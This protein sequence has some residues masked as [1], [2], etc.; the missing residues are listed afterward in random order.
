MSNN[1]ITE[2]I[3]YDFIVRY[4]DLVAEQLEIS[5]RGFN[6]EGDEERYAWIKVQLELYRKVIDAEHERRKARDNRREPLS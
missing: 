2:R 4:L 3:T 1:L 6:Q 5:A